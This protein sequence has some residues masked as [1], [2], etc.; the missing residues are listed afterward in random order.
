ITPRPANFTV[1]GTRTLPVTGNP[2]PGDPVEFRL[3]GTTTAME[4]SA[5][6]EPQYVFVAPYQWDIVPSSWSVGGGAP[7]GAVFEERSVTIA[8]Q[9]RQALYVSWP[10]GT[11]WGANATWQSL[12][13]SATPSSAAPAGSSA[14]ASMY[15]GDATHSFP[16]YA[17]TWG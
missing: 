10:P 17:A 13:V 8:G 14:V 11:S 3:F 16:G 2:V 12:F 6:I 5:A 15:I 1:N 9:A 4:P 7:A